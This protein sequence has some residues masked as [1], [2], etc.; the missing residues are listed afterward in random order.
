MERR[1]RQHLPNGKFE[2]VS[3][4]SS[5]NLSAVRGRNNKTTEVRLR[6]AL[7]RAG[8]R[9]W[10]L[11]DRSLP[12]CPDFVFKR[13]KLAIYVDGC[14]WHG[15]PKCGHIPK[16]RSEFWSAKIAR[17]FERDR[18]STARLQS[19]GFRVLRF[20]EHELR[21]ELASC[22]SKIYSALTKAA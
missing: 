10:A 16:T 12:G 5:K 6:L 1:L 4:K 21:F 11:H 3:A 19:L 17:N 22:V 15:C 20:W 2:N 8:I 9:G 7:V 13:R 18:E 14:F